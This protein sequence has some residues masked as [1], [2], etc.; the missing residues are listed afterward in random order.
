MNKDPLLR[1]R[2][3]EGLGD[4]I[5][6]FLHSKYIEP[7]LFLLIKQKNRCQTCD[8]RRM[9]LNILFPLKIWNLFFKTFNDRLNYLDEEFLKTN[10]EWQLNTL[11]EGVKK[12]K[13]SEIIK[14]LEE[15]NV[16]KKP[17]PP[18]KTLE[19]MPHYIV[20]SN[21]DIELNNLIIRTIIF[22]RI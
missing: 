5:A 2:C 20:K 8:K 1:F 11:D 6:C 9:A 4:L 16:E 7:I 14:H 22:E 15:K 13:Y 21:S 18:Q 19:I 17:I 3:A 10:Q 12:L